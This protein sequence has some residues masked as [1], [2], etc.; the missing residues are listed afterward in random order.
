MSTLD[1]CNVLTNYVMAEE[2][3]PQVESKVLPVLRDAD[4][5]VSF[6]PVPEVNGY[7]L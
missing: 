6:I 1:R 2:K 7:L 5:G 4:R 3:Y